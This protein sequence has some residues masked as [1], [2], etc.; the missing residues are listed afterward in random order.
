MVGR[1]WVEE[2]QNGWGWV[3][4]E[5]GMAIGWGMKM[6]LERK[7]EFSGYGFGEGDGLGYGDGWGEK[8]WLGE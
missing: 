4:M 2:V 5:D 3:G 6:G 8:Y 1:T 7:V